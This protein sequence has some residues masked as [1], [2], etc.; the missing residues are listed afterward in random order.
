VTL[1]LDFQVTGYNVAYK[2]PRR[3]IAVCDS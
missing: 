1:N 2:C 3:A